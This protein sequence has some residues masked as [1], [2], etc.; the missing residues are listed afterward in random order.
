M[1]GPARR[2]HRSSLSVPIS[3]A[4]RRVWFE[5]PPGRRPNPCKDHTVFLA[6]GLSA[7]LSI[8]DVLLDGLRIALERIPVSGAARRPAADAIAGEQAKHPFDGISSDCPWARVIVARAF[9]AARPPCKPHGC[10]RWRSS[11][12]V[13]VTSP[14]KISISAR[15]RVRRDAGPPRQNFPTSDTTAP[16]LGNSARA[17]RLECSSCWRCRSRANPHHRVPAGRPC[18]RC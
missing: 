13:I 16:G 10:V 7:D 8:D 11:R 9:G 15:S 4:V 14:L 12:N 18:R 6:R 2:G 3:L 5:S 17:I 1:C